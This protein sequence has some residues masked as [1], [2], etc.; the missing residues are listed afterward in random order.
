MSTHIVP[1][2]NLAPKRRNPLSLW[3]PF[4]YVHLLYWVAFFPQALRWS[5]ISFSRLSSPNRLSEL[6]K[7]DLSQREDWY[8]RWSYWQ[9]AFQSYF[10]LHKR[11]LTIASLL[12]GLIFF[13]RI[14]SSVIGT[15]GCTLAVA[16]GV[17]VGLI[18][19]N[20]IR[21]RPNR[22]SSPLERSE[23]SRPLSG[24]DLRII[25]MFLIVAAVSQVFISSSLTEIFSSGFA[26]FVAER[27]RLLLLSFLVPALIAFIASSS[28]ITSIASYFLINLTYSIASILSLIL[29]LIITGTYFGLTVMLVPPLGSVFTVVVGIVLVVL[30]FSGLY[31]LPAA[32]LNVLIL[33]PDQWI[34]VS[35]LRIIP[36]HRSKQFGHV[37]PIPLIGL[38]SQIF[39]WLH[40][41][42][43][44]ALHNINELLTYTQQFIPIV[45][46]INR[47]LRTLSGDV[48][49]LRISQLADDPFDWDIIRYVSVS[50]SNE[51]KARSI[52]S[53]VY[54]PSSVKRRLQSYIDTSIRINTPARA[55]AAGFLYLYQNK[56]AKSSEA[57]SKVRHLPHGEEMYHLANCLSAALHADQLNDSKLIEILTIPSSRL[58][59]SDTWSTISRL[60]ST[61]DDAQLVYQSYSRSNRSLALNRALGKLT[62]IAQKID[63]VPQAERKL[64]ASITESWQEKLLAIATDIGEITHTQP[65]HNPYVAGDP[66]EGNLFVGRGQVIK[67]LEE[68]WLMSNQLQSVVLYGHRRMGKTSILKNLSS[69]LGS[70]IKVAYINLLNLG[71]VSTD[72]GESEVLIALSDAISQTVSIS[73]PSDEDFLRLPS[74]TFQRFIRSISQQFNPGQGLIIALDE[75]EKI[76]ELISTNALSPDFLGF[77]R[78]LLQEYFNVAFAFAGLHTLEE[79]TEDY[80][81]PLFASVITIPIRFFSI[82]ETRELLANPDED[83]TLDYKPE[84]LNEI[85]RLTAGQPYLTQLIGSQLV[86]HYNHQVFDEGRDRSPIFTLDDLNTVIYHSDFFAKGRYYFTGVW[87]QAA[88]DAPG[89]QEILQVLAEKIEG[90]NLSDIRR[91]S[92][93]EENEIDKALKTLKR[94]D[95]VSEAD[96]KWKIIVPLF[97]QWVLE[98]Q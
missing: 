25:V 46:A 16:V 11:Y 82:G 20:P 44:T 75:F 29:L 85:Y 30:F 98:H 41:D 88:Q 55:T 84:T 56:P 89:Q 42:W 31:V 12:I 69:Y 52:Q 35:L 96:G 68:L 59:R 80:F 70:S 92:R 39:K 53:L 37:T 24:D 15:L 17:S 33:R 97:H 61:V 32:A 45:K 5:V 60:R 40:H 43:V 34:L 4:D 49:L 93:L 79:M 94:H 6:N 91:K 54:L 66:V 21:L 73:P 9:W 67:Q 10:G 2:L 65:I 3:N 8:I 22:K 13:H 23:D 36:S 86:R 71:A 28:A 63:R 74:V 19:A 58:L 1:R 64:V 87:K 7:I 18:S 38:S 62:E 77:L 78:G 48:L 72:Q 51:L 26:T 47:S 57:F 76:E 50:L 95:V 14:D 81:N 27:P 83:F 90:R